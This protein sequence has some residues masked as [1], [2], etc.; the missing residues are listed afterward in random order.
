M[1]DWTATSRAIQLR[2]ERGSTLLGLHSPKLDRMDEIVSLFG[3]RGGY[4][5]Q[6]V[7]TT[8]YDWLRGLAPKLRQARARGMIPV[9]RIDYARPDGSAYADGTRAPGATIPPPGSV[10]WCLKRAPQ[11]WEPSGGPS[12]EVGDRSHLA[13]WL[14]YVREAVQ[15]C[16]AVHTWIVGNE[17]NIRHEA[18]AFRDELIP[19]EH[20]AAVYRQTRTVIR[21][22]PGHENDQVVV[23]AVSPNAVHPMRPEIRRPGRDYLVELL[24]WLQPNEVDG[25]SIHAYGGWSH[26]AHAMQIF[27]TGLANGMGYQNQARLLDELGYSAVPLFISEWSALTRTPDDQEATARFVASAVRDVHEWNQG[28]NNHPIHALVWFIH[29]APETFPT[30]SIARFPALQRAFTD[31]ARTYRSTDPSRRSTCVPPPPSNAV[32]FF[33]ETRREVRGVFL[34]RWQTSGTSALSVFGFPIGD[35]GCVTDPRTGRILFSQWFQRHRLEYHPEHAGGP[36]EQMVMIGSIGAS[37]A[38]ERVGLDPD[39]WSPQQRPAGRR[40]ELIGP[41][42]GRGKWVCDDFLDRYRRDGLPLLGYPIS[43]EMPFRTVQGTV[44]TVQWFERARLERHPSGIEG[45]LLGCEQSGFRGPG[46]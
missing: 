40:C 25:V 44:I 3:G 29:D 28:P 37:L 7:Y 1:E 31:A 39:D 11:P 33:S 35:A 6:E 45:G 24:Y 42:P 9:L 16:D 30:E 32:R 17:M 18:R 14:Q 12:R 41:Q 36:L 38:R 15:Q 27:R 43:A 5:V 21:S 8:D 4:L 46:C 34:Q 19:P 23:G 2:A 13:C 22:M 10:G 26:E 20:Y